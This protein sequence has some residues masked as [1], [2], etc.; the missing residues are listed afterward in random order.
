MR[1]RKN[2]HAATAFLLATLLLSA[3][4]KEAPVEAPAEPKA[5]VEA[6]SAV[7]R[8]VATTGDVIRYTVTVDYDDGYEIEVPE[9]GADIAGFRIIDLGKEEPRHVGNRIVEERWYELRADLVGSYVLPPVTVG[10]RE[11]APPEAETGDEA[12]QASQPRTFETVQTS[13]IFVEVE[14]VLPQ[15]GEG[16]ATDIRDLKPLE[17]IASPIPWPWI[18]GGAGA[19][20]A[21]ALGLFFWRRRPVR[22]PPP[23]PAHEVAFKA[24]DELRATDF[25]D[26]EAVRRFHFRISEVL[27]AYVEGRFGLNATDL[28]TE[29]ILVELP[30]LGLPAE[31]TLGLQRFLRA[32][33]RVKFADYSPTKE[34]IQQTYEGGL[35]FVEATVPVPAVDEAASEKEAA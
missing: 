3:C 20:L 34:E 2:G 22:L 14:S 6:T 24:L 21:L 29:E 27:R 19:L 13:A 26:P 1:I 12:P 23:V 35:A 25:D 11:K 9:P 7:D 4:V 33:D 16:E 15:D 8:A 10:Y 17:E 30:G 5:P 31:P 32:T 18:F 28:T